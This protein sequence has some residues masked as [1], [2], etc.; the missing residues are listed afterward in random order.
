MW[1][2]NLRF[3]WGFWSMMDTSFEC[4]C[5]SNYLDSW[6]GG[7]HSGLWVDLFLEGIVS[8]IEK[9]QPSLSELP[10]WVV[11][12]RYMVL[13]F[14]LGGVLVYI[15]LSGFSVYPQVLPL[16]ILRAWKSLYQRF[17]LK[18]KMIRA[19]PLFLRASTQS[20]LYII[21]L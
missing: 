14:G 11:V 13:F 17:A 21:I 18:A 12:I 7:V 2:T 5:S 3:D 16:I 19:V 10:G 8:T 6:A 1:R 4:T 9:K 15:S 20:S